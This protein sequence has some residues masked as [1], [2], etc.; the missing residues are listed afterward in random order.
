MGSHRAIELPNSRFK[1]SIQGLR[2]NRAYRENEHKSVILL[3]GT[4]C[5]NR[6]ENCKW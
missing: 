1:R 4:A 3:N 6:D 2:L 5:K